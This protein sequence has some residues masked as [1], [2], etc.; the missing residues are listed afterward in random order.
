MYTI[1]N[2]FLKVGVL[3]K[4]AELRSLVDKRNDFE[5][6]WQADQKVWGKSSPVLFPIVGALKENRFIHEGHSY[7][8][9]RH[10]FARDNDFEVLECSTNKLLFELTSDN[11]MNVSYPFDFSLRIIYKLIDFKLEVSYIVQN[12]GTEQMYFSLGAH[13][14]FNLPNHRVSLEGNYIEFPQDKILNR[15]FLRNNLLSVDFTDVE[16]DSNRLYLNA[17]TFKEDAWIMKRLQ[18]N[19]IYL[20]STHSDSTLNFAFEKFPSFGIWSVPGS[21]FVCLEPWAGLP[22]TECHKLELKSKEGIIVLDPDKD[23]SA[24]WAVNI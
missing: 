24:K 19:Q 17:N 8:L 1:E 7:D 6:M 10:G 20:K 2:E 3:Q 14:A 16:L 23:W 4:G 21:S 13:P 5:W 11:Q 15:Y 18:S 12:R 9:P 22:D